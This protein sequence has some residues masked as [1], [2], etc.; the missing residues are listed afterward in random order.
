MK[1]LYFG[2]TIRTMTDTL[3][4]AE[5]L[6]TDGGKILAVG[7]TDE[8]RLAFPDAKRID[9]ERH[10]LLPAFIDGHSHITALAQTLT[11]CSLQGTRSFAEIAERL[12]AFCETSKREWVVGFGYD[13]TQLREGVHATADF[14][15]RIIP[16]RPAVLSHA[17]GHMGVLNSAALRA[18]G[19]DSSTEDP[20]GGVIGRRAD[21]SPNGYL[22]EAA[23]TQYS[24]R[25]PRPGL[26]ETMQSVLDAEKLYFK[27]GIT[28]IQDGITKP[29]DW[30]VLRA[31]AERK[32]FT[33]DVVSYIDI[34]EGSALLRENEAYAN[35]YK[36]HLRIGG[37]KLFLDGS[38]QGRTA[39]MTQP[40]ENSSDYRGYP[41]HRDETVLA[42]MM[43]AER[44]NR[45]IL[46]HCN[47]DAAADQMIRTYRESFEAYQND[48][49]PVMVHAQ[50]VRRDQLEEMHR[51]SML[52]SFFP[53]HIQ[54]WGDVHIENF[55]MR[56]A[57]KISPIKS[58]IELG[59]PCDFHQDTPV[60]MPDMLETLRCVVERRTENGILL[61]EDERVTPLEALRCM[62]RDA[63]YA[64][65]EENQKGTLEAGKT[66]D[67]VIL[68]RDPVTCN[69]LS[70]LTVLE[71]IKAGESVY[72]KAT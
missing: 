32:R 45:Q 65:F 36:D 57:E 12:K 51:S 24:A 5:A 20:S 35:G 21:G 46:V 11:L 3:P 9:L 42:C 34:F 61:G 47:G 39:W 19:I 23:F 28:T 49:R 58:A 6:V 10:T 52:A 54:R 38:P 50:L 14:L 30:A 69:E 31:L 13:H 72:K 63:A 4:T 15:D 1:K 44:E 70:A 22:E 17:S 2:G 68:N 71:T 26:E 25:M 62:T 16:D 64:Y 27:Y 53:A 67:L 59:V 37:Y 43:K 40:Y 18:L 33:A 29:A 7:G 8:L 66:A 56:R 48:I 55:G 60:L 41:V